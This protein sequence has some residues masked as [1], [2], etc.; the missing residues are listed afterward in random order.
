MSHFTFVKGQD[1]NVI[2]SR[3]TDDSS[4]VTT[5]RDKH[6]NVLGYGD[7]KRD[8]TRNKDG[9]LLRWDG[10]ASFLLK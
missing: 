10:D 6:G 1:G 4:G 7:S 9:N 2:G 5:V 3:T 8:Q